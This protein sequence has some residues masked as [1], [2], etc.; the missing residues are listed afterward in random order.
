MNKINK[1]AKTHLTKHGYQITVDSISQRMLQNIITDLTIIPYRMDATKADI[2]EMKFIIYRYSKNRSQIVVPRY[3]GISKFGPPLTTDFAPVEAKIDFLSELRDKQKIVVDKC[4]KYLSKHGGG[5]LSVPCGF[6]K[7]VCALYIAHKLG[8]KTLVVVH[9]SNLLT[10]WIE[11]IGE[12]LGIDDVGIIQRD[13]CTTEGKKIVVGMIQTI[14]KREYA[15]I[16]DKFGL[17]IYDEAHHVA[18]KFFS[19]CLL[20]TNVKYTLSLTATPYRGDGAIKVMYWF[21]GGTIYREKI[22]LNKNVIVK[23]INHKSSNRR[24]FTLKLRY[25]NGRNR[26]DTGKMVTNICKID[27]R[28]NELVNILT[29]IRRTDP[30]RKILILSERKAHLEILKNNFDALLDEDI[31]K[32]IIN[33][34]DIVSCH[35]NGDTKIH[36]RQYAEEHGDYIFATYTMA[37]EGLDIKH[38]NTVVLASPKKDIVQ[39]VGRIMRTILSIGDVRPMIIDFGDNIEAI[40]NWIKIRNIIY[41]KCCYQIE[42]FYLDNSTYKT[43]IEYNGIALTKEDY[44]HEDKYINKI[45]NNYN[46]DMNYLIEDIKTY[47]KFCKNIE[48]LA[49]DENLYHSNIENNNYKILDDLEYTNLKDIFF[50]EK[51]RACDFDKQV[52]KDAENAEMINIEEDIEFDKNDENERTII[53]A[54]RKIKSGSTIPKKKLF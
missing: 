45:I 36:E 53:E 28:N 34:D 31:A 26:P 49:S 15:N 20:K 42:N 50:V 51:L 27:T 41:T 48:K 40:S 2:E 24:L 7:T 11:R 9:K 52:L 3:Y 39:S 37:H 13:K 47:R 38:L 5:L 8:L 16:F 22:K 1:N 32:G 21:L 19:R 54:I 25:L 6:G 12:F 33:E 4:L 35:Y 23:M 43:F 17:V 10:Q 44:H 46:E 18:A 30:A 14:A 29:H